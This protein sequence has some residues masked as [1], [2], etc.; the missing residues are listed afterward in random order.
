MVTESFGENVRNSATT[1]DANVLNSLLFMSFKAGILLSHTR[2][3]GCGM[4]GIFLFG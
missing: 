3:M 4:K 2:A 1:Y